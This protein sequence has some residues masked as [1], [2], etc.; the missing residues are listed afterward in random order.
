M[1]TWRI[2]RQHIHLRGWV[3]TTKDSTLHIPINIW[4]SISSCMPNLINQDSSLLQACWDVCWLRLSSTIQMVLYPCD[5]SKLT[6]PK[7][8]YYGTPGYSVLEATLIY[9]VPAFPASS[10]QVLRAS[11]S[12]LS[13]S[14]A[15]LRQHQCDPSV[16]EGSH[17]WKTTQKYEKI[18]STGKF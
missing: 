9:K 1:Q 16:V 5:W 2:V 4:S 17:P 10:E 12:V 3:D 6:S 18:I 14:T 15:L 7:E 11:H 8:E 13:S